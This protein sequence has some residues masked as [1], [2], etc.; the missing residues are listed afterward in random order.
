MESDH[1][2]EG[3]D[4]RDALLTCAVGDPAAFTPL[5]EQFSPALHGYF[6]RRAPGAADDLLAEAWL[7]AFAARGTFDALRDRL[8]D[9]CS[10]GPRLAGHFRR[11]GRS[12]SQPTLLRSTRGRRW[13]S[14]SDAAAL[15]PELRRALAD[16][17]AEE[18]ELLLLASWED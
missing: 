10:G 4:D 8:G 17:P 11:A 1:K 13:T 6:A 15:A 7:Q 9:G 5:V 16:L 18:R 12:W 14:G 3:S 2:H